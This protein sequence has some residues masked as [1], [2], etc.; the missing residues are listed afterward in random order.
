MLQVFLDM[1][2]CGWLS[3]LDG[4]SSSQSSVSVMDA[5]TAVSVDIFTFISSFCLSTCR[6]SI[7]SLPPMHRTSRHAEFCILLITLHPRRPVWT[8]LIVLAFFYQERGQRSW[9]GCWLGE[10]MEM[11]T[12]HMKLYINMDP[13]SYGISELIF[14]SIVSASV[15]IFVWFCLLKN[16]HTLLLAWDIAC[17]TNIDF[18]KRSLTRPI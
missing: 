4:V 14:V 8:W 2:C 16:T 1:L 11:K 18:S 6:R 13:N 17:E 9:Q 7:L 10:K 5:L 15:S 12:P 3:S